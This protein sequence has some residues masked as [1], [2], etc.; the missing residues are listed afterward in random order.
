M[1][2]LHASSIDIAPRRGMGA[3]L[4]GEYETNRSNTSIG[5][6][7]SGPGSCE[8]S[9]KLGVI[10]LSRAAKSLARR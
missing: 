7:R 2:L 6:H 10:R 1:R 9:A 8:L 4:R 5:S 3:E